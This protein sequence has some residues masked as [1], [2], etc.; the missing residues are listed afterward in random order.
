[1]GN[2]FHQVSLENLRQLKSAPCRKSLLET[3]RNKHTLRIPKVTYQVQWQPLQSEQV[4]RV[5][6]ICYSRNH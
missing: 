5:R 2:E 1:M 3:K 4:D 6:W